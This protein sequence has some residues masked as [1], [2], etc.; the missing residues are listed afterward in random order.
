M[1]MNPSLIKT[2]YLATG[3]TAPFT[4]QWVN[5][6]LCKNGFIV[7]YASG[8]S[9]SIDLQAKTELNQNPMFLDGGSA[10]AVSFYTATGIGAGYGDPIFF[11][12]PIAEIRL[13]ATAGNAPVFAYITYQN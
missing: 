10:E 13:A 4:G 3:Q 8:S 2:E 12:S 5:T 6:A 9:I 7:V 1:L 11:D